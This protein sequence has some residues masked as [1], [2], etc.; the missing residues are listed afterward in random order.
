MKR[1]KSAWQV[2]RF[3]SAHETRSPTSFIFAATTSPPLNIEPQGRVRSKRGPTL[4]GLPRQPE[5]R[6]SLVLGMPISI[7]PKATS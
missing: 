4:A 1:F 2:Q 5:L 3:L 6:T 7:G